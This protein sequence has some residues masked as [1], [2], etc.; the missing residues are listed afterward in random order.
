MMR[1]SST[2]SSFMTRSLKTKKDGWKHGWHQFCWTAL[3]SSSL[4][5]LAV[6]VAVAG[7]AAVVVLA[8]VVIAH[9]DMVRHAWVIIVT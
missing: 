3:K 9:A 2:T 8:V 1:T 6:A 5:L 4:L 7:L